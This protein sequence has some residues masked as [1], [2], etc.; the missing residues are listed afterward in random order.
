[1]DASLLKKLKTKR[2]GSG[3]KKNP[4]ARNWKCL[5]AGPT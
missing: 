3:E 5:L 1:V 4:G 2:F